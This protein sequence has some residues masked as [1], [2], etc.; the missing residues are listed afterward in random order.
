MSNFDDFYGQSNFDS[1]ENTI[2][3]EQQ[4]VEVCQTEEITIV[5][6]RLAVLLDTAKE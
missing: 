3:I 4:E 2:I 5:Q 1:S 6:Q